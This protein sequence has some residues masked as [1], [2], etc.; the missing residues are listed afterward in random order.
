MGILLLSAYPLIQFGIS[1]PN[2]ELTCKGEFRQ[3]KRDGK[4]I[5]TTYFFLY[6]NSL[7]TSQ[8]EIIP[9]QL[10]LVSSSPN[11]L[12]ELYDAFK[13]QRLAEMDF[14]NI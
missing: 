3:E 11:P 12:T 7:R 1:I 9:F 4:Y 10:T 13:T 2:V 8:F 6:T 5:I 14:V